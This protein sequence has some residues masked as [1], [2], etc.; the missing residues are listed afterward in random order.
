MWWEIYCNSL[1]TLEALLL[2][3]TLSSVH[4]YWN[5]K[6]VNELI[7]QGKIYIILGKWKSGIYSF[8][9]NHTQRLNEPSQ[10]LHT[11]A[12]Y[13]IW[14]SMEIV[15]P[16]LNH[17]NSRFSPLWGPSQKVN[18]N[19]VIKVEA[20]MELGLISIRMQWQ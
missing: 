9:M 5:N 15:A 18:A 1:G 13:F 10:T 3:D 6:L 8:S 17:L 4:F 2:W 11:K 20:S 16:D 12:K 7:V 14:I 19:S